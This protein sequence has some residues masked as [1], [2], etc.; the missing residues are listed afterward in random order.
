MEKAGKYNSKGDFSSGSVAKNVMR[1]AIPITVAE[2]V[3]VL[4]NLVDRIYL[5]HIPSAG[6]EALTSIGVVLP[7]ITMV[8]AFANLFGTGG[9]PL[10]SIAR[11]EKNEE[12]ARSIVETAFSMLVLVALFLTLVLQI[13]ARP[14]LLLIGADDI[15]L[16][17]A[18]SYFRVYLIGT[19]FVSVTLG[20]NPFINAQGAAKTGMGTVLI[21]AISNI[22]LDPLFIFVFNMGIQGAAI[23]TVISQGLSALWVFRFLTGKKAAV[24]VSR[25]HIDSVEAKRILSLGVSGFMFKMTN[26]ITQAVCNATLHLFGGAD[27]L[28][29]VGSMSV[30]NSLREILS[31]P[32]SGI[33][34]GSKP[35]MGYNYGAGLYSR[36]RKTILFMFFSALSFNVVIW[37]V[38][39]LFPGFFIR[40]FSADEALI[41]T[42]IPCMKI[43]F[44]VFF[45]M[46]FQMAGQ[47]T[48]VALNKPKFAVFFSLFRKLILI[49]PLTLILP[50]VGFGVKGVFYAE[51][52]SQLFGSTACFIT[53]MLT[54]YRKLPKEDSV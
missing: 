16:P 5:G 28:L 53:M 51:M 44:G 19:V 31:Q 33:S 20:M 6:T 30:I 15:T 23:A 26:S 17:F 4:Y 34:E 7:L 39:Q 22:L 46:T 10:M 50:R 11:G 54:V 21:G 32:V 35:V 40:L 3:N 29:Y 36:V 38:I 43:Y 8:S 42:C 14:L 27:A 47:N 49:L 1:L 41:E 24:R 12:K 25:F 37:A 52:F 48:F 9:A 45:L 13:F 18:L 2:I